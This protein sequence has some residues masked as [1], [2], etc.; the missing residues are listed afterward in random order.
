MVETLTI[1]LNNNRKD[2]YFPE[3]IY[4]L[5]NLTRLT[6]QTSQNH[7]TIDVKNFPYLTEVHYCNK[8]S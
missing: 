2:S 4:F 8:Q 6:I 3:N 7:D 5:S 1:E